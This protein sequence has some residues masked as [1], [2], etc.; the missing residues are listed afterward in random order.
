MT[1]NGI[2]VLQGQQMPKKEA[3][4][5][6]RVPEKVPYH[7]PACKKHNKKTRGQKPRGELSTTTGIYED[8]FPFLNMNLRTTLMP[9]L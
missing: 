4:T 3:S 7:P 6:V 2:F 5:P 8:F 9:I 1:L